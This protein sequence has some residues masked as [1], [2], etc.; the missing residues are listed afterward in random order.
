MF[1][2]KNSFSNDKQWRA[3]FS[4]R[5]KIVEICSLGSDMNQDGRHLLIMHYIVYRK[6]AHKISAFNWEDTIFL[7]THALYTYM[8]T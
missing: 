7:C 1:T 4:F 5:E 6:D 8:Y 2:K 3:R